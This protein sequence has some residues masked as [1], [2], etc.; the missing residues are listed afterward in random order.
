[1]AALSRSMNIDPTKAGV[2][3]RFG[4]TWIYIGR[5]AG[6]RYAED[7]V[8]GVPRQGLEL[9]FDA[10]G[11]EH[12]PERIQLFRRCLQREL[13][14]I[15]ECLRRHVV[16]D[17]VHR[18]RDNMKQENPRLQRFREFPRS[19]HHMVGDSGKVD[20]CDDRFHTRILLRS[21]CIRAAELAKVNAFS[22]SGLRIFVSQRC[23]TS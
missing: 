9:G 8:D 12:A 10:V 1:M 13:H 4:R 7:L 18:W 22:Q 3:N 5:L 16:G 2:S 19:L 15:H 11:I 6:I 17:D 14:F 23:G 20:G 21:I